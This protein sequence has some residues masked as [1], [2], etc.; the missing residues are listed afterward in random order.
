[1]LVSDNYWWQGDGDSSSKNTTVSN[2]HVIASV[3]DA[4]ASI[5]D[6][7]GLEPGYRGL[8]GERFGVGVPDAPDQLAAF[9]AN[10]AAYVGWNPNFV[11]HGSPVTSYTVTATPGGQSATIS[12]ADLERLGD[13]KVDGLTN[14]TGYTFTATATNAAGTSAA[15]LPT[16]TITPTAFATSSA[17]LTWPDVPAGQ[18]DNVSAGG[19]TI[20]A[21]SASGT[22]LGFLLTG[23]HGPASGSGTITYTDGSTQPFTLNVPDWYSTPPSG[24]NIAFSTTYRNRPGNVQQTHQVNVFYAGID[25]DQ[26]KQVA[27]IVLPNVSTPTSSDPA[28]HIFA[29]T[30]GDTAI[31]LSS[32]FNNVGVTDDTNT[33]VGNIDGSGSSLSA[34]AL[35]DVGVTPG[36]TV[37]SSAPTPGAPTSVS[38]KVGDG[39]VSLHFTPP[40]SP[41]ITPIL[42]YTIS[43]PDLSAPVQVTGH[44]FLWAGSGNGLYT[45]VGGLTNGHTYTFKITADNVAGHGRPASVTATPAGS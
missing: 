8:L 43:S 16:T 15:S 24:S 22:T 38:A 39:A 14:G 5:V 11:D 35:A 23:T 30:I 45:V 19:Q 41:G 2:N 1:L 36:S 20:D 37:E 27:S 12:A 33:D 6:S 13:V 4:P 26:S 25:L 17:S 28:I 31:D 40:S 10:G 9:G 44:D 7:A 34:Q 3:T 32:V 29:M 21:G 18:P 42:G